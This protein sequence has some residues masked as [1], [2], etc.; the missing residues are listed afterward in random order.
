[1][2]TEEGWQLGLWGRNLLNKHYIQSVFNNIGHGG[3]ASYLNPPEY[4]VSAKF[5]F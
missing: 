2:I 1:L 5:S 3:L 4:G